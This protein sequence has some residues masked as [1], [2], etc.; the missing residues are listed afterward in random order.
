MHLLKDFGELG[1]I[2]AAVDWAASP[3]GPIDSWS[4]TLRGTVDM[5]LATK[6]PV[7][8]LWGPEFVLVYNEAYIQMIGDK[9][10]DALGK[11][12]REVFPEAM[13]FIGPL[14]EQAYAGGGPTYLTDQYLPLHRRGFLEEC[15][16][17][18]AYSAVRNRSGEVEGV[19][20]ITFET[21][22]Q[23]ITRRRLWLLTRL[24]EALSHVMDARDVHEVATRLLSTA[25]MDLPS[26]HIELGDG[27]RT[28][29][30]MPTEPG[31][32]L[33]F[34]LGSVSTEATL[35]VE[36]SPL[37]APDDDYMAFLG[38]VA[39]SLTQALERVHAR[40]VELRSMDSQ[41]RM[42]E[43]F[44]LSL[45][46][47][48]VPWGGAEVA[49]RYQP[50]AE[51]AQIGGDWYDQFELPDKTLMMVIGDVSGHDQDAAA[52]M[53]QVRNMIRGIAYSVYPAAPS[54]I[55]LGLDHALL[56]GGQDVFATAVLVQASRND[57]GELR[58]SWSNAGHPPPVLVTPQGEAELLERRPDQLLGLDG[59]V[60]ATHEVVL[61]PGS[62]LVLY[63]DGL[64]ERRREAIGDSLDKL[65]RLLCGVQD[66]SAEE[67][68]D[69]LLA[70]AVGVED[71]VAL[72][73]LRA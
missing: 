1:R 69:L 29:P 3:L 41:R 10:P 39:A 73:V 65:R 38:L 35:V 24:N 12:T 61:Q 36:L 51:L 4:D 22:E 63:T 19:I 58:L 11:P 14:M 66:R 2:Y 56:G 70:S 20:D 42:S 40:A 62:T 68:C 57:D 49:V 5:M 33:R 8:L 45:L 30:E 17:N 72:L 31:R 37:L 67:I 13:D 55:L 7:T 9:H 32:T 23:V 47:T 6:F 44:Q 28:A 34:P 16:F 54:S 25:T 71:D 48:P 26:V 18:F 64:V 43:A 59:A 15:Y 60:R 27:P 53:A 46:P 50:A 21:T 52:A